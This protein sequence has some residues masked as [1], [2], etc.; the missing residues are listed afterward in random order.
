MWGRET[1]WRQGIREILSRRERNTVVREGFRPSGV[2]VPVSRKAGEYY[3]VLTK[4]SDDVLYHKGQVSFPGGACE[5]GDA[6][7]TATALRETC[8]EVGIRPDDVEV[9]GALD[10]QATL[11]SNFVITPFV[12]AIPWP[13]TFTV[14]RR[15][16]EALIEAPVGALLGPGCYSPQTPDFDGTLH[17]WGYYSYGGHQITGITARIL[18]QFLDLVFS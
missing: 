12:G 2:L 1:D 4:R 3:V 14:N 7:L 13:Y 5:Q 9:L 6:D 16:V 18:K 11:S 15:E 10:D 17:P 8:E